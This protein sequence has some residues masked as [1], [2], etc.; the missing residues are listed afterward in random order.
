MSCEPDAARASNSSGRD[1]G[2]STG[3]PIQRPLCVEALRAPALPWRLVD[4]DAEA[5]TGMRR[6]GDR[7]HRLGDQRL[8][9]CDPRK[10]GAARG[11]ELLDLAAMI[12]G[13]DAEVARRPACRRRTV[14]VRRC[15]R[16][17]L[18]ARGGAAR[19]RNSSSSARVGIAGVQPWRRDDDG[20]GGVA[21]PAAVRQRAPL[22]P[23]AQA[24]RTG[25]RRRRRGRSAPRPGNPPTT[26]PWSTLARNRP[27]NTTQPAT[28][29]F[30]TMRRAG[31]RT[32][33]PQCLECAGA[34]RRR[35][36]FPPRCRRRGQSRAGSACICR[37]TSARGF[38][39]AR[40][41]RRGRQGPRARADSRCR[42]RA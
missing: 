9:I 20:A 25:R 13:E 26:S 29:R 38:F 35:C 39:A 30:I 33:R 36:G 32:N 19:P 6:G 40:R 7:E 34:R 37:V 10:V 5:R 15:A 14:Q 22:D 28:P 18:A 17:G 3:R 11:R 23:A 21:A 31:A 24:V 42:G 16:R 12:E 2:S 41:R 27:S 1:A 4:D 8:E